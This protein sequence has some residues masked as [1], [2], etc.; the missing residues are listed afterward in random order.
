[1]L[2]DAQDSADIAA[3]AASIRT[4]SR[5][6][7]A[8]S[9][10]LPADVR[11]AAYAVYAFCRC[12]DDAVDLAEGKHAAHADLKRRLARA[13]A[14]EPSDR[15]EDR[16]FAAVVARHAIPAALPE[17][18]L[19]GLAW[20]ARY[21]R[22]ATLD[23]LEQYA[24]RVAGSVGA[25]MALI[26]GARGSDAIARAADLGAAM[27]LT[28]IVRDIGEDARAGRLYLPTSWFAQAGLDPDA[29]LAAPT[30]APAIASMARRLLRRADALYARGAAGI[31]FLPP[32]CRAAIR[33]ASSLYAE[34]GRVAE[35][36]P[37]E[38]MLDR[39]IVPARRKALLLIRALAGANPPSDEAHAAPLPANAFLVAAAHEAA[40]AARPRRR[41][42]DEEIA[43]IIDLVSRLERRDRL[44]GA[45]AR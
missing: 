13:Y 7:F 15:F 35:Q 10:L 40:S 34:I 16:A 11:R 42:F 20:D 21:R 45:G 22:Y 8:A 44:D 30:A 12:S 23:D 14:G 37:A 6:F 31:V 2:R 4:G 9:L 3:C 24:A 25:I 38:A 33:A 26:M 27:Q 32:S 28:N 36:R 43:R 5:T 41:D 17:A 19:E 39:A 29:W 1:M 18:L